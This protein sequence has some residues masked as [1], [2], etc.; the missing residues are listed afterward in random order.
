MKAKA[1][2]EWWEGRVIKKQFISYRRRR[3]RKVQREKE[4]TRQ[5]KSR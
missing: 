3:A 1:G 5:Y 2:K 4:T